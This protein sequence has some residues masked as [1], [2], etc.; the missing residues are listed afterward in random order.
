MPTSPGCPFPLT[1]RRVLDWSSVFNDTATIYNYTLRLQ[2]V[3]FFIG[4]SSAWL[5]PAVRHVAKGRKKCQ[6]KSSK[7]PPI[8]FG[9]GYSFGASGRNPSYRNSPRIFFSPSFSASGFRLELCSSE[10][11][12]GTTCSRNS[13]PNLRRP[14]WGFVELAD[15]IS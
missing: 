5:T 4:T 12:S 10:G 7:F 15:T 3:C 2:K 11:L 14:W 8:I 13:H 9:S 1:E 6:D